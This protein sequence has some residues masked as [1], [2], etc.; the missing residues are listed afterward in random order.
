MDIHIMS[1]A[2]TISIFLPC[3][4]GCNYKA[5]LKLQEINNNYI[6]YFARQFVNNKPNYSVRNG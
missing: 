1:S 3:R 6:N 5:D 2:V 4:F